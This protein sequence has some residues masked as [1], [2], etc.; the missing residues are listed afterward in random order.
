VVFVEFFLERIGADSNTW[1]NHEKAD[2]ATQFIGF[3]G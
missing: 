2:Q 1:F 3:S